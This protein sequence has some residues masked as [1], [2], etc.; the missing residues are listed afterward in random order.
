MT[1]AVGCQWGPALPELEET[2]R[3]RGDESSEGPVPLVPPFSLRLFT[4]EVTTYEFTFVQPGNVEV[5]TCCTISLAEGGGGGLGKAGADVLISCFLTCPL[6]TVSHMVEQPL[7]WPSSLL[8]RLSTGP[9]H[10]L[11]LSVPAHTSLPLKALLMFL[12]LICSFSSCLPCLPSSHSAALIFLASSPLQGHNL[13]SVEN[14]LLWASQLGNQGYQ[15]VSQHPWYHA[16]FFDVF[17]GRWADMDEKAWRFCVVWDLV[18]NIFQL[19]VIFLYKC[20]SCC[21]PSEGP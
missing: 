15:H 10:L 8:L 2:Q 14:V 11:P 12:S 18:L 6:V 21:W 5:Q 20:W 4:V 1:G 9:L 13:W 17:F 16:Q 19:E 3:G 7:R